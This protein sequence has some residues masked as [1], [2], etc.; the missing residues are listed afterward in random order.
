[1]SLSDPSGEAVRHQLP[2]CLWQDPPLGAV[3]PLDGITGRQ[4]QSFHLLTL[5][6][7]CNSKEM[8]WK[9][10]LLG[11]TEALPAQ[12][13]EESWAETPHTQGQIILSKRD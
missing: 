6:L 12:I 2:L 13:G 5:F 11:Q 1:M 10:H 9:K 7:D 8:G 4:I 3:W